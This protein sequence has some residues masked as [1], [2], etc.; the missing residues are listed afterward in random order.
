MK[1]REILVG[2]FSAPLL[3]LVSGCAGGGADGP[4]AEAPPSGRVDVPLSFED[5]HI[6]VAVQ[7]NGHTL[8]FVLD[9]GADQ[10]VVTSRVARALGLPITMERVQGVGSGGPIE[11]QGTRIDELAIGAARLRNGAAFIVSA[12]D[13]FPWDG[14]VGANFFRH[15]VPRF[16]YAAR[17]LTL[18]L[19]ERFSAPGG[20]E[21]IALRLLNNSRMLV[22][23]QI[24]GYEGW[25]AVDTGAFNAVTVHRPS[26]DRLGLR[27]IQTPSVRMITG[28]GAGG[29]TRGDV[30]RLPE[31]RIG[32][33][34]LTQVVTELSL[35]TSGA[36]ASDAFMGNLGSELFRRF[37]VTADM[38]GGGL[39]LEP[40]A[41][42]NQAFPG[43]RSG[44]Y[45]QWL[46]DRAN[47]IEVI[48]GSPAAQA[49]IALN[50]T[51]QAVDGQT[52]AA[53]NW[54]TL[55]KRLK[56]PAGT[57]VTLSLRRPD[58]TLRDALLVL[59]ELV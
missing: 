42:L 52:L 51:V 54:A 15:F 46:N 11:V 35:A 3:A 47:V 25:F 49:D 28:Q 7:L 43:P 34:R 38:A 26:V 5:P 31:L 36:F 27:S 1:R 16:N 44:M 40:N 57:T 18:T 39:Y 17:Q 33:W 45:L 20:V 59:R 37:I 22:Q 12:P 19:S 48:A 41:A 53:S 24:A 50:D 6:S 58:G 13:T 30:V 55:T 14:A 2:A 29:L 8:R 32:P 10:T 23:A 9:T 4:S 21:R 56:Q